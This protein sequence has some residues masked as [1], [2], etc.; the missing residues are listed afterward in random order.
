[1]FLDKTRFEDN[2]LGWGKLGWTYPEVLYMKSMATLS[3]Y[4]FWPVEAELIWEWK[5]TKKIKLVS[6]EGNVN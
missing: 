2:T 5:N 4:K 3:W 1:M 6:P